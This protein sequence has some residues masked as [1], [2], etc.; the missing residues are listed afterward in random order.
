M[1][2]AGAD[3]RS[4]P[5]T[6]SAEPWTTAGSCRR[7]PHTRLIDDG[8]Y[9]PEHGISREETADAWCTN[10]TVDGGREQNQKAKLKACKKSKTKTWN[11]TAATTREEKK[12]N[13]RASASSTAPDKDVRRHNSANNGEPLWAKSLTAIQLWRNGYIRIRVERKYKLT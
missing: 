9:G 5:M 7:G 10:T 13:K 4:R 2:D 8:R 3:C 6:Y 11:G 1:R 12:K